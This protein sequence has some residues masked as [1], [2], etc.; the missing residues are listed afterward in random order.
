MFQEE[1][2]IETSLVQG[3]H[4]LAKDL[5]I[6][7]SISNGRNRWYACSCLRGTW[8]YVKLI[9]RTYIRKGC[10]VTCKSI[11]SIH[12]PTNRQHALKP[13]WKNFRRT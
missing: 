7:D 12:D 4:Q 9:R 10:F 1:I 8:F 11:E 5:R 6:K 2:Q 13:D 3:Y